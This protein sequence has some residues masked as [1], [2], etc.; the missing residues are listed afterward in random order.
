[1]IG[2]L[3]LNGQIYVASVRFARFV[4]ASRAPI[5]ALIPVVS[6]ASFFWQPPL[7][8]H[9]VRAS[10]YRSQNSL[11]G[12]IEI[13]S[14]ILPVSGNEPCSIPCQVALLSIHSLSPTLCAPIGQFP[15][16]I[17]SPHMSPAFLQQTVVA[18]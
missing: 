10:E 2:Q 14:I 12:F 1:M 18:F 5:L 3:T 7:G 6:Q 13:S 17:V 16:F 8:V 4:H 15:L 9:V 11:V